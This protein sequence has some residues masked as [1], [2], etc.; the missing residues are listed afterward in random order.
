MGL[1]RGQK[2]WNFI[3]GATEAT[4][5][6]ELN[7]I[8]GMV[9]M[10]IEIS[11]DASAATLHFEGKSVDGGSFYPVA[12]VNL[13]TLDIATST[14]AIGSQ[15][16]MNLEGL[17]KARVRLSAIADNSITVKARIVD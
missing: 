16:Q 7:V 14:T 2:N 12:S 13:E 17:I 9:T 8:A 3:S 6:F 5:G 11:G 10:N 1:N 15:W 4:D